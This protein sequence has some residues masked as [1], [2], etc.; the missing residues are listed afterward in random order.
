MTGHPAKEG[1]TGVFH[2]NA[3]VFLGIQD[4]TAPAVLTVTQIHGF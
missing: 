3:C 4:V 2:L 1:S